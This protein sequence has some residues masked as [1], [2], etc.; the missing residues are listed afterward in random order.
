[1][2]AEGYDVGGDIPE[3][4]ED[5][6][7]VVRLFTLYSKPASVICPDTLHFKPASVICPCTLHF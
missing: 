5:I 4:P 3:D 1:M 6:I 2:K 7:N